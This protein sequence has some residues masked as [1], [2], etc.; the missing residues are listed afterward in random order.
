MIVILIAMA[1][2]GAVSGS[3][4]ASAKY[5]VTP[6]AVVHYGNSKVGVAFQVKNIGEGSGAPHCVV[7]AAVSSDDRGS[8]SLVLGNL[9]PGQHDGVAADRDIVTISGVGAEAI[10]ARNGDVIVTCT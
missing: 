6:T 7:V 2:A 5:K 8:K 9:K 3:S 4:S 10:T 1:I